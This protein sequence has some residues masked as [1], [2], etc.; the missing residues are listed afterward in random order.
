MTYDKGY[1]KWLT[2]ILVKNSLTLYSLELLRAPRR[3]SYLKPPYVF[4]RVDL[5]SSHRQCGLSPPRRRFKQCD[6]WRRCGMSFRCCTCS[7]DWL[8]PNYPSLPGKKKK[9]IMFIGF[10]Q[11]V[12]PSRSIC[13]D[14]YDQHLHPRLEL[15]RWPIPKQRKYRDL[16]AIFTLTIAIVVVFTRQ[17]AANLLVPGQARKLPILAYEVDCSQI[18]LH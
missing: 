9:L 16:I 6:A 1:N 15:R 14:C 3:L 13:W 2:V 4:S 5:H 12:P 8:H 18:P 17:I 10:H 7:Q 11:M